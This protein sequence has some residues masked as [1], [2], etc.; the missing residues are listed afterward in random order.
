MAFVEHITQRMNAFHALRHNRSIARYLLPNFFEVI[1][2]SLSGVRVDRRVDRFDVAC[3]RGDAALAGGPQP[4]ELAARGGK[5][6]PVQGPAPGSSR[7]LR[8]RCWHGLV[9]VSRAV[10]HFRWLAH[11]IPIRHHHTISRGEVQTTESLP[12]T[13]VIRVSHA[14]FDPSEFV[15]INIMPEARHHDR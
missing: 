8:L 14:S 3:P 2:G 7:R 12:A 13:A 4:G 5:D 10:Q 1:Q 9:P 6:G 11:Y 15:E